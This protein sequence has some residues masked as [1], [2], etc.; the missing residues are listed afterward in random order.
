[1]LS[2]Y[3]KFQELINAK[4]KYK[5]KKKEKFLSHYENTDGD[6]NLEALYNAVTGQN[7]AGD[8]MLETVV[9]IEARSRRA[10]EDFCACLK[11]LFLVGIIAI[12]GHAALKEE[13]V[14][15]EMVKKWQERMEDVETRMKAAV[16]DCTNNFAEQAKIDLEHELKDKTGSLETDFI[17]PILESLIKKYDWI[18]WSIRVFRVK[19]AIWLAGKKFHGQG[20]GENSFEV[21]V[22]NEFKVVVSFCVEP[23]AINRN[24]YKVV[25]TNNFQPECYFYAKHKNAFICIHPV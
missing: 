14:D 12:M 2:Q 21:M 7:I 3:E 5:E 4:P 10:V 18:S 24:H 1:M 16:E 6:L 22:N 8:R 20:G 17:K 13:A 15:G 19:E 25:E 23:V 9:S 11:K